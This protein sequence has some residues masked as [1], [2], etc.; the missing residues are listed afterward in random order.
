MQ[1]IHAPQD[2]V[3]LPADRTQATSAL[4]AV[5]SVEFHVAGD[6]VSPGNSVALSLSADGTMS[7]ALAMH[8]LKS[9]L[10]RMR[11]REKNSGQGPL[12]MLAASFA[13]TQAA[14]S[15]DTE[16]LGFWMDMCGASALVVGKRARVSHA[17]PKSTCTKPVDLSNRNQVAYTAMSILW[18]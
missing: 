2:S 17:L 4:K 7:R 11:S 3:A 8:T 18:G 9:A 6:S 12:E 16:F 10:T 14:S 1:P 13:R 15:A 5:F